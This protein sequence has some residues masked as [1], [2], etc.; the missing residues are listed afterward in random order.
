MSHANP[1]E[2]SSVL[3]PTLLLILTFL[4]A[5]TWGIAHEQHDL[6]DQALERLA[7]TGADPENYEI[8]F[9][10][11]DAY[12]GGDSVTP[13]DVRRTGEMIASL[14]GVRKVHYNPVPADQK[15]NVLPVDG[16][17]DSAENNSQPVT[18]NSFNPVVREDNP[19][20]STEE[21]EKQAHAQPTVSAA[22]PS[23]QKVSV[24]S[25]TK[26]RL[27][28]QLDGFL[29]HGAFLFPLGSLAWPPTMQQALIETSGFLKYNPDLKLE[30]AGFSEP[31][32]D[33]RL[34]KQ[35]SELRAQQVRTQL[36]YLG[37]EATRLVSKGYG[38]DRSK[39][40]RFAM[41][42]SIRFIVQGDI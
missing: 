4:L 17:N 27:Q 23:L 18:E 33:T 35:L 29:A 20:T 39:Q 26:S 3:L 30:I 21:T 16:G 1:V 28:Y 9:S 42:S 14:P 12:I 6:R 37:V 38:F 24:D 31:I 8:R 5:I 34:E 15:D 40:D 22:D 11:R 13:D 2:N 7:A 10:G 41:P 32:G 36:I 25:K 19:A